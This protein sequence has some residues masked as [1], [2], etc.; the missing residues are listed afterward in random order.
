ME[1]D[2]LLCSS[3]RTCRYPHVYPTYP[4]RVILPFK[5]QN[6]VKGQLSRLSLKVRTAIQP[7]FVSPKL[8]E[9]LK[10]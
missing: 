9:D 4:A 2:F 7:V 1:D 3:P 10:V 8:N 6:V 5:D